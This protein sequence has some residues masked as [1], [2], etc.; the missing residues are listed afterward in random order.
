MYNLFYKLLESSFQTSVAFSPSY[1]I[2]SFSITKQERSQPHISSAR[3]KQVK[4]SSEEMLAGCRLGLDSHADVSCAGRHAR[5]M[6]T[7]HGQVCNVSPFND[8]YSP[9]TNVLTV[10]VAY[11]I[12]TTDGKTYILNVNQALDFTET[13]EHSLLCE[14]QAR[15]NNVVVDSVPTTL[16][17]SG[18]ST[19]SVYFPEQDVR[20]PLSMRGPTSYLP[21]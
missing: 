2:Q 11:A 7:F 4:L 19:H 16:D 18:T 12:D 10:N 17:H 14:N 13:M 20:F 1:S 5:I 3:R 15:S 9:M 21:V 6:E 8:A